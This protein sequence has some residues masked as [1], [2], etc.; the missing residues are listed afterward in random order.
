MPP[1]RMGAEMNTTALTVVLAILG[2]LLVA[3][4]VDRVIWLVR[5]AQNAPE[6]PDDDHPEFDRAMEE[7]RK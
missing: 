7:L 3:Y 5:E 2:G 1:L 6:Q 4:F